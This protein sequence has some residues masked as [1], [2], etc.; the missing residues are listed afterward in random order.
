[1]ALVGLDSWGFSPEP[2]ARLWLEGEN[3][4]AEDEATR[5]NTMELGLTLILGLLRFLRRCWGSWG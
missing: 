2:E 3:A 5:F 4:G 1:M